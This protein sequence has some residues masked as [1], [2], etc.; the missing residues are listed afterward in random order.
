M[1]VI[2]RTFQTVYMYIMI[3]L[4]SSRY[5]QVHVSKTKETL[6]RIVMNSGGTVR[7]YGVTMV[8]GVSPWV[9]MT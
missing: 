4:D 6:K 5:V 9:T 8:Y 2:L 1:N 7:D 3:I